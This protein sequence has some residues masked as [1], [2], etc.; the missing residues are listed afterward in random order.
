MN[1]Q[2]FHN[3]KHRSLIGNIFFEILIEKYTLC[4][5]PR[6]YDWQIVSEKD[7]YRL[8]EPNRGHRDPFLFFELEPFVDLFQGFRGFQ[9]NWRIL[10]SKS[11]KVSQEHVRHLLLS[12]FQGI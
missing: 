12:A 10:S 7:K 5:L 6:L 2:L 4:Y 11:S 1:N 3:I 8:I 9:L